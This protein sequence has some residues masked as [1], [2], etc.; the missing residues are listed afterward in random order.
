MFLIEQIAH[1]TTDMEQTLRS[2]AA[3]GLINRESLVQDH[4]K[5]EQLYLHP[6]LGRPHLPDSSFAVE[7]AFDYNLIPKVELE[8]IQLKSG[9]TVQLSDEYGTGFMSHYG[10]HVEDWKEDSDALADTLC[11]FGG[12]G[13]T[14]L[15]VSQTTS[16]SGTPRR[17]RYAFVDMRET[18]GVN[19]KVIQRVRPHHAY[20]TQVEAGREA[21]KNL[22]SQ[23]E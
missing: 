12:Q 11:T 20:P 3:R 23:F 22:L 9:Y 1:R 19:L 6:S 17:Y 8:F 15:Q 7:L 2:L 4:V 5:A 13:Y 10:Y 18:L 16:H 21:F 14:I